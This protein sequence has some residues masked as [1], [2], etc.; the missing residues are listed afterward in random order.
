[1]V[2]GGELIDRVVASVGTTA[3]T[4]SEFQQ[5]LALL[6]EKQPSIT[7]DEVINSMI[8]GLL[9]LEKARQLR[10]EG[11]NSDDLIAEYVN[12]KIRSAILIRDEQ[13]DN[14]L[15]DHHQQLGVRNDSSVREK[16][17]EL[18]IEQEFNKAL[19]KHI[20]ELRET[21]DIRIQLST[22]Q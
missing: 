16:V 7:E 2:Y 17:E 10:I 18:L 4:L 13:I 8:N 12:L 21:A 6:R 20:K 3:I 22:K 5:R 19:E 11:K 15:R 9:L 1:V 14:Y